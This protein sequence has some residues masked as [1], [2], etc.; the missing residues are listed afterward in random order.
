MISGIGIAF[1]GLIWISAAAASQPGD[2]TAGNRV[3]ERICSECHSVGAGKGLSPH[4]QAPTFEAIANTRSKT[5]VALNVWLQVPH[6]SMPELIVTD[7]DSED[8]IAYILTLKK[9]K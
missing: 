2:A 9:S 4:P 1:A 3:A 6:G 8:V 5:G 7:K